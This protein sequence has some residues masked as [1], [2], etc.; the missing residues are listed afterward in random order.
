MRPAFIS[1]IRKLCNMQ[2]SRL[3]ASLMIVRWTLKWLISVVS[4]WRKDIPESRNFYSLN[5]VNSAILMSSA[6]FPFRYSKSYF[7]IMVLSLVFE[8]NIVSR[9]QWQRFLNFSSRNVDLNS[10]LHT[11]SYVQCPSRWHDGHYLTLKAG[12]ATVIKDVCK[13]I[14]NPHIYTSNEYNQVIMTVQCFCGSHKE[15]KFPNI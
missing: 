1:L 2:I 8:V 11:G 3:G 4:V 10:L 9:V 13:I 12:A 7:L 6:V 5:F 15:F 14:L